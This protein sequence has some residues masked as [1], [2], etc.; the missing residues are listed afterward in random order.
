MP[1]GMLT[2]G[3]SEY[4]ERLW[5]R[6]HAIEERRATG[7]RMPI[8]WRLAMLG[9]ID[10]QVELARLLKWYEPHESAKN[11]FLAD[12]W[13]RRAAARAEPSVARYNLAIDRR[14]RGDMAGYRY[15]LAR[16]PDPSSREELKAFKTRFPHTVMRRWHRYVRER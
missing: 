8:Y 11:R 4:E 16:D 3:R 14:N 1:R 10:A 15:W 13:A 5:E 12:R 9:N 2:L 6:L 7:Y